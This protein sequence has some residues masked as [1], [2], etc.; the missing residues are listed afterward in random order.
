MRVNGSKIR[1][2]DMAFIHILM[3]LNI[4]VTG[5]LTNSKALVRKYGLMVLNMKENIK[6]V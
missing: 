1:L 3:V 4:Q 5:F 2:M 6:K